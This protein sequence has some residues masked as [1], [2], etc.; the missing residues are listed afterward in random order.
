MDATELCFLPAFEQRGLLERREISGLELMDAH[1]ERIEAHNSTID[2]FV[3][4]RLDEAREDAKAADAATASGAPNGVL[5]G[6]PIG[7]KDCFQTKGL[8]TTM[9]CRA[10]SDNVPDFDHSVVARE[11]AAGAIVLGKLNTPEFTMA[12]NLCVNPIFA[13]TRNPWDLA[14]C[15]GVSSGGSG[16]A[17]AAGLCSLADGSD[18]GGSVRNPAAWCNIVGHRPTSWMIPDVPNSMPWHN[19]NTPGPMARCV[20]DAELFLSVL[21][22]PHPRSPMVVQAPFPPGLPELERDMSGMR[23]GWS[24]DHGSLDIE[25]DLGANFDAQAVVFESL[26]CVVSARDIR[27]DDVD[28]MYNILCYERVAADTKTIYENNLDG[29]D[30]RLARYF[31]RLRDLTGADFLAAHEARLALWHDVADAFDSYDVL[32]WPNEPSDAYGY[33]DEEA[34]LG[35]DWRLLYVA[36]LLGLPAITVPCGFSASGAPRGIQIFGAPGADLLMAQAAYA[37]EQA[38]GYGT[39]RPSL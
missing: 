28:W 16:A 26:G 2:A 32:V 12:S 33:D 14:L 20:K 30:P 5:H 27:M 1:I 9:G 25:A 21:A 35:L 31:E 4:L 36:P 11:K 15:P 24:R 17:L 29:L 38:T 6:L 19:M 34:A 13:A 3:T 10:L 37:Y 23:V 18:I 22:G 8:R 7:V 39:R